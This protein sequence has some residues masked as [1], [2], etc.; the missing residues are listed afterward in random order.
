[1]GCRIEKYGIALMVLISST[2]FGYV[3]G[4]A[5]NIAFQG[6]GG[7]L[8]FAVFLRRYYKE[9]ED[10]EDI[11]ILK[12]LRIS[13]LGPLMESTLYHTLFDS[14]IVLIYYILTK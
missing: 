11:L 10:E 14:V 5:Y 12:I 8:L 6:V 3:H 4:N 7:L 13:M 9:M 1:M 2:I